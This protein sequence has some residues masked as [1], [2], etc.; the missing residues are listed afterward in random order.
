M[1]DLKSLSYGRL[2]WVEEG[3]I[4]SPDP[5]FLRELAE[6]YEVT[7]ESLLVEYMADRYSVSPN[8]SDS[9][10]TA[11][12]LG[13]TPSDVARVSHVT[14]I[15][16]R[17]ADARGQIKALQSALE[18]VEAIGEELITLASGTHRDERESARD[19]ERRRRARD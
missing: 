10:P 7:Y 14:Q 6:L 1:R 13:S 3:K 17:L 16:N 9:E 15:E 5:V 12:V 18:R 11:A 2:R 4:K 8:L 19:L